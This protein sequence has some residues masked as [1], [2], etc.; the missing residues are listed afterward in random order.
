MRDPGLKVPDDCEKQCVGE[1]EIC[2]IVGL[3][4]HGTD[5]LQKVDVV[6]EGIHIGGV[7]TWFE[8]I[9]HYS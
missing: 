6:S 3:K 5:G 7:V 9:V 4:I 8:C 1:D 2:E